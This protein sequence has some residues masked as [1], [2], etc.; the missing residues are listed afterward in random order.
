MRYALIGYGRMGRAIESQAAGRGHQRVALVNSAEEVAAI[1]ARGLGDAEVAFEFTN[2]SAAEAN[3]RALIE[4]GIPVVCGTTGWQPSDGWVRLARDASTG[5]LLAPNF[6]VGVH[7]FFRVVQHAARL[8]GALGLHQP[9]I[10]ETHHQGKRDVP[11]GTAR[12]LAEILMESI[13][14]LESVCEG[15]PAGV[16]ESGTVQIS[17]TRAGVEPGTHTVGFD[18]EHD[19][20]TLVHRAGSRD[21]F[22]LGAVLAA[23]WLGRRSGLYT[24]EEALDEILERGSAGV[25][26]SR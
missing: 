12:K 21:G 6:S 20:I 19:A 22:A 24:L 2:G 10:H 8:Y 26:G 13:P 23:E 7:L 25:G 11:S 15:N 18:G 4:A 3:L 9:F 16:I 14:G 17:S 5:V 1:D